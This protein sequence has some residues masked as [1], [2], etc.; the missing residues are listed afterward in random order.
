ML[1]VIAPLVAA[2][3]LVLAWYALAGARRAG[4]TTRVDVVAGFGAGFVAVGVASLLLAGGGQL[5]PPADEQLRL[6]VAVPVVEEVCK[7][8]AIVAAVGA[9]WVRAGQ[10]LRLRRCAVA[11]LSVVAAFAVGENL[12]YVLP[13]VTAYVAGGGDADAVRAT[14]AVRAVLPPLG[15]VAQC[16]PVAA[17]L[18]VATR[19]AMR[20]RPV[21]LFVGVAAAVVIHA[22]WNTAVLRWWPDPMPLLW[23]LVGAAATVV[24][25]AGFAWRWERVEQRVRPRAYAP[26]APLARR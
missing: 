25:F 10:P 14:L 8:A 18:W 1:A 17:A 19:C 13:Q 7:A 23:I 6:A 24:M 11:T 22:R 20:W 15:H 12:G 9:G 26:A 2:W 4:A 5:W 3:P 21:A 16:W